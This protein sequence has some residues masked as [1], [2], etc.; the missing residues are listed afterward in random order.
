EKEGSP[1]SPSWRLRLGKSTP[2]SPRLALRVV[3]DGQ[4][5]AGP[6][7]PDLCRPPSL[8]KR[9]VASTH[10]SPPRS[11]TRRSKSLEEKP[12]AYTHRDEA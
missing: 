1:Q 10:V 8:C 6:Q 2:S 11:A 9:E 5:K 4:E 12:G 7:S 3:P